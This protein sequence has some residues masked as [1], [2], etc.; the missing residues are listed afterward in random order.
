M[1][2]PTDTCIINLSFDNIDISAA[3]YKNDNN[4]NGTGTNALKTYGTASYHNNGGGPYLQTI[5]LP[6]LRDSSKIKY[7]KIKNIVFNENNSGQAT[8]YFGPLLIRSNMIDSS[9]H[10]MASFSLAGITT[11][12]GNIPMSY[13]YE[14]NSLLKVVSPLF[15]SFNFEVL[16]VNPTA[17][18][19]SDTYLSIFCEFYSEL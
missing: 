11:V 16:G 19:I 7:V 10:I 17:L 1:K 12:N 2:F 9:D 15:G 13:A 6:P 14:S 4:V 18:N 3:T 8:Q 5:T